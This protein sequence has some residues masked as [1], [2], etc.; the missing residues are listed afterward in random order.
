MLA[1]HAFLGANGLCALAI[2]LAVWKMECLLKKVIILSELKYYKIISQSHP[3]PLLRNVR[4][5]PE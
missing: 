3:L 2:I 4:I 1:K 5:I